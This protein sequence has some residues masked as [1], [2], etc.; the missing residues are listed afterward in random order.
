[1]LPVSP[2]GMAMGGAKLAGL[3]G[4]AASK[5]SKID[6]IV[7]MAKP[8][9][10]VAA[11]AVAD[12]PY[13]IEHKPMTTEGGAS[14]LHDLTS[15][16]GEDIYGRHALEYFGSGDDREKAIINMLRSVRG[17]PDA[18]V[19]IYRGLPSSAK[20]IN[21]GDW[22]TLHP[23]VAKDYSDLLKE[24]GIK[25]KVVKMEVPASSITSWPDS[26]LEFGYYPQ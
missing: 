26:L 24:Q 6:D 25:G 13:Q 4:M 21:S 20:G 18:K 12:L 5:G 2:E 17:N 8:N 22:V 1:M 3:V 23:G 19:T 16:F 11:S 14:R 10:N 9:E 7:K 15:S